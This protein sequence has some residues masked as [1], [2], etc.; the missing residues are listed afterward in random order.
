[1]YT[2]RFFC[3]FPGAY[4]YKQQVVSTTQIVL[5]KLLST[6]EQY[7]SKEYRKIVFSPLHIISPERKL[8]DNQDFQYI[9]CTRLLLYHLCFELHNLSFEF[10][11]FGGLEV[12][13]IQIV[14]PPDRF[15]ETYDRLSYFASSTTPNPSTLWR[16]TRS[17][18]LRYEKVFSGPTAALHRRY[19]TAL[20]TLGMT[21][22]LLYNF[23]HVKVLGIPNN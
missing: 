8:E 1:M 14:W 13:I 9:L 10:N 5:L 16:S 23:P 21:A 6:I 4:R 2:G 15:G 20:T 7:N 12:R 17:R 18:I 11:S 19:S 3:I 22:V